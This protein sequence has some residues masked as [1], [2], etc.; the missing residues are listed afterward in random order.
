MSGLSQNCG[1]Y[2][3]LAKL[4]HGGMAEVFLGVASGLGGFT[5]L[6]VVKRIHPQLMDE[7]EFLTMFL[8][9]A[10]LAA[11]LSHPNVVHTL[12]VNQSE[13]GLPFIAMEYLEGQSLDR[14]V[15]QARRDSVEVARSFGLGVVVRA[16][17]GLHYAH[18][19]KDYDG[20]QLQVVHR[21]ISPSNLFITY[22]GVTKVLDFG[23][24]KATTQI[25]ETRT[26]RI[27][28]KI[29]YMAPEQAKGQA[30]DARA[31]V[32]SMGV[33]LWEMLAQRRLFKD[34]NDL[35]VMNRVLNADI[36]EIRE[37]SPD[38]PESLHEIVHKALTVD[39]NARFASAE[40]MRLAI[41]AAA[42][43][44][45]RVQID[46]QSVVAA[47]MDSLFAGIRARHDERIRRTLEAHISGRDSIPSMT[48][49][50]PSVSG[51]RSREAW[52]KRTAVDVVSGSH[53]AR[54]RSRSN[55]MKVGVLLAVSCTVVIF[56]LVARSL[57]GGE[58]SND[59]IATI[60]HPQ[61]DVVAPLEE[62]PARRD[63]AHDTEAPSAMP[64][65]PAGSEHEGSA[66]Q[67]PT[68]PTVAT[69][70]NEVAGA[71]RRNTHRRTPVMRQSTEMDEPTTAPAEDPD[72]APPP[73]DTSTAA[74]GQLS[75]VTAPWSEVYLGTRRLGTTPIMGV[76]LPEGAHVLTLRNPEEH[77][78][79]RYTVHI[80]AGE[81]ARV[82]ISLR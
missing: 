78:E 57:L 37:V 41:E 33:V 55:W 4:G 36:P 45:P 10:R 2:R 67:T 42:A 56:G 22:Q 27:K 59:E 75:L 14:V 61:P 39:V 48:P 31:D 58:P 24:A 69:M 13:D 18:T 51:Q 68:P 73:G 54:A 44:D 82:R 60:E 62:R 38:L 32:W 77:I 70:S 72:P 29:S 25:A 6:L 64:Q 15:R 53:A 16:L 35:L 66:A 5:K 43:A 19:L 81:H 80:R 76:S 12:E 47:Q 3:L 34:E 49:S 1:K 23:I 20:T 52:E 28:G 79:T 8:D 17:E 71:V 65:T 74:Q 9:E 21:D 46:G 7:P 26:G 40:E 30:V 11:R 50:A 63:T